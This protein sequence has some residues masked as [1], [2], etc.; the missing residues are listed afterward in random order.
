LELLLE[1]SPENMALKSRNNHQI[2]NK[3]PVL[4][5]IAGDA[6]SSYLYSCLWTRTQLIITIQ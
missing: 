5:A 2:K 1:F 6:L 4:R 3:D